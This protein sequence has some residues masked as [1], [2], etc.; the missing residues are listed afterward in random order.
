MFIK[1]VSLDLYT[2]R[3]ACNE[4]AIEWN[5]CSVKQF[6]C[7]WCI[8]QKGQLLPIVNSMQEETPNASTDYW[9]SAYNAPKIRAC[10]EQFD[11]IFCQTTSVIQFMHWT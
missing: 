3:K 8:T 6:P 5:I 7:S 9:N 4:V 10:L 11:E 1:Q 2:E